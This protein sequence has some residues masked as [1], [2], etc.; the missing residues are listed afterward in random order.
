MW[1]IRSIKNIFKMCTMWFFFNCAK[2][3]WVLLMLSFIVFLHPLLP[4]TDTYWALTICQTLWNVIMTNS[5]RMLP[6]SVR[7]EKHCTSKQINI[8]FPGGA[9]VKNL[10]HQCRWHKRCRFNPWVGK[11]PWSRKWQ[12]TLVFLPGKSHRQRS[13]AGYSPSGHRVRQDWRTEHACMQ[14]R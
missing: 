5:D 14:N 3:Y 11:I 9:V 1:H 6:V 7:E 12:P 8:G 2:I 10:P 4:S 13:L